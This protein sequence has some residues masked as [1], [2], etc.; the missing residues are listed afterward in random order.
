MALL[1]V[2]C[3]AG[4]CKGVSDSEAGEVRG[5]STTDSESS[6]DADAVST[7]GTSTS[8]SKKRT[9][10]TTG[11]TARGGASTT[12]RGEGGTSSAGIVKG[13]E[14]P[15]TSASFGGD[16]GETTTSTASDGCPDLASWTEAVHFV[17]KASWDASSATLA[18]SADIEVLTLVKLTADGNNLGGPTRGCRTGIPPAQLSAAGQIVTGGSKMLTDIPDSVWD[19]PSMGTADCKGTQSGPGISSSIEYGFTALIGVTLSDENGPWPSSG[20]GLK[21]DDV[22]G[23]GNPGFTSTPKSGN[24]YVLPPTGLGVLGSAPSADKVFIVS[25]NIASLSGTRTSCDEHSGKATFSSFDNHVVG[26][27]TKSGNCTT[28]QV[29]FCDQNRPVYKINSA[30]YT[31]RRVPDDTTC[32]EVRTMFSN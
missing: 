2:S 18:G 5:I 24:G 32:E 31:A 14:I 22:D 9:T 20:S 25:R 7:G 16:T 21:T 15:S 3:L 11:N 19:S 17:L 13:S 4:S 23:D 1:V 28:S 10:A 8:S 27:H 26:C 12:S 6:R 30:T 29:D